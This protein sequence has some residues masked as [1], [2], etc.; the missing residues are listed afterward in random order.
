MAN[1]DGLHWIMPNLLY[2]AGLRLMECL[3][4]RVKDIDFNYQQITIRDGKGMKDRVTILP[5]IIEKHLQQHLEKAKIIHT[6]DL[7]EG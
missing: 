5:E 4:L 7:T 2:G 6:R 3:R 1:L